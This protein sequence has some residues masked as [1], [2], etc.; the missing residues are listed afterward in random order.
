MD[1][2]FIEGWINFQKKTFE[3]FIELI[4]RL[5]DKYSN[6]SIIIRPHPAE[7]HERWKEIVSQFKKVEV[8][9]KNNVIEW[10]LASEVVIHSNCTTGV[11][12]F[13]LDKPVVA[14]RPEV[15]EKYDAQLPNMV[16][17]NVFNEDQ[18]LN[19]LDDILFN[20]NPEKNTNKN[21][22]TLVAKKYIEALDGELS[23]ERIVRSIKSNNKI[24]RPKVLSKR[25]IVHRS[26]LNLIPSLKRNAS[27]MRE[28]IN[29]LNKD[30]HG[31]QI[32]KI[33][34]EIHKQ[35]IPPITHDE[36]NIFIER[37]RILLGRFNNINI[38]ETSKNCFIISSS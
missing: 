10:I 28:R 19:L 36:V 5:L 27:I 9:H 18:L 22:R 29:G 31:K 20:G 25:D 33:M 32:N 11:E 13:I 35:M 14:Y 23:C 8:I 2:A 12:A 24:L 26:I 16:C 15:S 34:I 17:Q 30:R 1:S 37:F 3:A 4:P 7:K 21:E 6:H 38:K